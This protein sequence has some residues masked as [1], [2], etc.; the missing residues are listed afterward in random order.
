MDFK[1]FFDGLVSLSLVVFIFSLTFMIGSIILKPYI[2]LE[3]AHMYFIIT[4]CIINLNFA[5]YYLFEAFQFKKAFP[6]KDVFLEKVAKRC[7][8]VSVFYLFHLIL[9]LSLFFLGLHNLEVLMV[10]LLTLMETFLLGLVFKEVYDL[11]YQPERFRR[12]ELRN[13]RHRYFNQ[14]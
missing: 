5:V 4:L 2:A 14:D 11:L 6:L 3:P 9:V 13:N 1:D 10:F 8:L 12:D 7:G